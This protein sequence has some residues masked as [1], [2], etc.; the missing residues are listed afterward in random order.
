MLHRPREAMKS[1]IISLLKDVKTRGDRLTVGFLGIGK[2]NRA[3]LDIIFGSGIDAEV[4]LRQSRDLLADE[5]KALGARFFTAERELSDID[6]DL[7]FV[8]PSVRREALPVSKSTVVV[9]DTDLFFS[10]DPDGCFLIT[11]SDGKS[12][13]TTL[14]AELLKE[15]YPDLFV[16]GN[17]GT[18][19]A[20]C[21]TSSADAFVL[22]LSSFNL[23]YVTPSSRRAIITNITP[24]HLNWHADY[25]EYIEAKRNILGRS[26]EPIVSVDTPPCAKIAE[27]YPLF[28]VCSSLMSHGELV[29]RYCAEHTVTVNNGILLDGEK[30]LDI[31]DVYLKQP[32]GL[33]NLASAVAMTIGR[34]SRERIREI[35]KGFRGL[36]HRCERFLSINGID[37]INSS[38]DTTPSRTGATLRGLGRRVKLILGGRGKGLPLSPLKDALASYADEIAI[39]GEIGDEIVDFIEEDTALRSIPH[40]AFSTLREAT[41]HLLKALRSGDTLLLSPAATSYGD[42]ASFE[43]RGEFFKSYITNKYA[44]I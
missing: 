4:R 39:Y 16:G 34:V 42:F 29:K 6:E 21:D 31:E 37:F 40:A 38:I 15:E 12:T 24:N 22:E 17:L 27:E 35:A 33:E 7:L 25:A 13:T 28:A 20:R 32:H 44:K 10:G 1:K 23:R 19:V 41:D 43:E 36:D 8:S 26:A 5:W 9:S 3:I 14:V 18:P 2:T 30:L 11:G